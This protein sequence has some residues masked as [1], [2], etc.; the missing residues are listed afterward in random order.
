MKERYN[1]KSLLFSIIGIWL[2]L[3]PMLVELYH[4]VNDYHVTEQVCTELTTHLHE[5][6][7]DCSL[8]DFHPTLFTYKF[9]EISFDAT[10][11]YYPAIFLLTSSLIQ[12]QEYA[13]YLLRAPPVSI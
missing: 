1:I 8:C 12:Q 10:I 5:K 9:Q 11:A 6:S 13:H 2:L 4:S 3:A 7:L